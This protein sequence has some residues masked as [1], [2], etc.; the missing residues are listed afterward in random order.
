MNYI[1]KNDETN[2]N[3]EQRRISEKYGTTFKTKSRSW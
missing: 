2:E 1:K 3:K